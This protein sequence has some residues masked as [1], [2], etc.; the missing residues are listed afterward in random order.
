MAL[1]FGKLSSSSSGKQTDPRKLFTTLI[2]SPRFKRPLDEQADVLDSWY[3][4]R[5]AKDITLKM[6]TGAG[7]T[8][9]GLLCLQSCLNEGVKPAVYVT[10]DRFLSEQVIREAAELGI[11]VTENEKDAEFLAGRAILI[12]NIFKLINGRSVFGVGTRRIPLGAIV[13]DDAHACLTTASEQFALRIDGT[14]PVYDRLFNLFEDDLKAQSGS[15]FLDIKAQD[16]QA[17]MAVPYWAWQSKKDQVLAILHAERTSEALK[18]QWPLLNEVIDL[19]TCAFGGGR[20]EIAPRFLP[21]DK[22]PSFT[23]AQRRIYMTATLADDTILVSHFQAKAHDIEKPIVPKGGGDLGDRMILAPQEINPAYTTDEIKALIEKIAQAHNVVVI[24]PSRAR[25]STYWAQSANQILDKDS[26]PSGIAKLRNGHVGLTILINKY[27]GIDLPGSACDML[28]IDGLPEV[29]GLIERLDIEVTDGTRSQLLRQIQRIEQGM[30]R[31]VRSSDDHCVVLLLGA[32]LS[33]RMHE[34]EASALFSPATRAQVELGRK[35]AS[36]VRGKPLADLEPVI[37]LCLN[38]DGN[39]VQASRNAVV[40]APANDEAHIDNTTVLL[41]EAFDAAR[42]RRYDL[43]VDKVQASLETTTESTSKGYLKQQLA[44]YKN[45]LDPAAAQEIQ[46]SALSLNQRILRPLIGTSYSK[47]TAPSSG[48]AAAAAG[49]MSGRFLQGND[50]VIFT[51]GLLEDLRWD[52]EYSHRFEAA[53]RDLGFFLGFGSQR[54][55]QDIG[56]GPDNLWALGGLSYSVIEC[57]SGATSA[58]KISKKDTNQL[59]GSIV[60]F[61]QTYD[62]SCTLTPIMVHPKTEFEFAAS[63]DPTIRI[64]NEKGLK[65]LKDAVRAYA[66]ALASGGTFKESKAVDIQLRQHKL[67]AENILRLISVSPSKK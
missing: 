23:S 46:L 6:N 55:E 13:V 12:A 64:V 49:F 41:R 61:K 14:S 38:Q 24:T 56:K 32:R 29:H 9:V 22:I 3:A 52:E 62:K 35:V 19:C 33:Q 66:T 54:P 39:W 51:N 40:N 37:D 43:A 2:R 53:M 36:Q 30:G 7:K 20:I 60:W 44:E 58:P 57:K 45:F 11:A 27:D 10:P 65:T 42:M 5:T 17:V 47:L 16:P 63:P 34:T 67:D 21:I 50:L 26:I 8:V 1:D 48:Q 18:W 31:G 25:A 4:R 59:N 28:V 15:S